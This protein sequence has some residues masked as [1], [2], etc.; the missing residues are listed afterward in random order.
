MS[1]RSAETIPL[2][3]IDWRKGTDQLV[4]S[5]R[6]DFAMIVSG[7]VKQTA[8]RSCCSRKT[9]RL[10]TELSATASESY[11]PDG[12][13]DREAHTLWDTGS[14]CGSSLPIAVNV[15][16]AA[17]VIGPAIKILSFR[18]DNWSGLALSSKL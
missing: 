10:A 9:K 1:A 7:F 18:D 5:T 12:Y 11:G 8:N 13:I 16:A 2:A 6:S 17:R 14:A 4:A 3:I 15:G